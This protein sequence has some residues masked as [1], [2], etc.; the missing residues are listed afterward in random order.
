MPV[1]EAVSRA[2]PWKMMGF[3]AS[4]RGGGV[5]WGISILQ[6]IFSAI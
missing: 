5:Q 4:G 3:L 6:G 2:G 1:E